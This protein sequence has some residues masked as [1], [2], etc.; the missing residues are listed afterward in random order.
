MGHYYT[1]ESSK[2]D[3]LFVSGQVR[4]ET[5]L[6]VLDFFCESNKYGIYSHSCVMFFFESNQKYFYDLVV[7]GEGGCEDSG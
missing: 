7:F 4:S 1:L 3:L 2:I 6:I 5:D